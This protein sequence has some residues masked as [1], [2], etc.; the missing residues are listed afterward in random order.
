MVQALTTGQ[1]VRLSLTVTVFVSAAVLA[2]WGTLQFPAPNAD[3]NQ[4]SATT[5]SPTAT[6]DATVTLTTDAA[7]AVAG[8]PILITAHNA[9]PG[10]VTLANGAPWVIKQGAATVFAPLAT[11]AVVVLRG[12]ESRSWTWEQHDDQGQPV[13]AGS[14]TIELSYQA[15]GITKQAT[16]AVTVAGGSGVN[17]APSLLTPNR[18]SG[19]APL[20]VSFSCSATDA[21]Y[22]LDFGDGV[23]AEAVSCPVL[24]TH[25]FNTAGSYQVVVTQDGT[26]RG[27]A[28]V[29]VT[30]PLAAS[31]RRL[32][33]SG[34][35][36]SSILGGSALIGLLVSLVVFRAP[37]DGNLEL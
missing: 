28:T 19:A 35:S 15:A 7:H 21:G 36:V 12:N 2:A 4:S 3:T 9:G 13:T 30:A 16:T 17:P 5:T 8:Q 20:Q 26:E 23:R 25:T 33:H 29:T 10:D 14:Y 24:L 27:R 11:Q 34:L 18:T 1:R 22:T 6:G 37:H 32:G 31:P